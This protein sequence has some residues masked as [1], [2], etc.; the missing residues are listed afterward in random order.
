MLAAVLFVDP[1]GQVSRRFRRTT[2]YLDTP[3]CLRALGHE[4]EEAREAAWSFLHLARSQGATLACFQHSVREMRGIIQGAKSA[5]GRTVGAETAIRGVARHFRSTGATVSD[6]DLALA[7]LDKDLE[8]DR[9]QVVSSPEHTS[10]LGLDEAALEDLLQSEIGYRDEATRLADLNSLTAIHRLRGGQS[11]AHLETCRAVLVTSNWSLT[12]AS[13]RFFNSG[14]HEWPLVMMDSS[15]ATLLWVKAP[16]AQPDLPK[17]QI[18]ADCYAAMSPSQSMWTKF[19]GETRR[20][21]ERG[22]IDADS[23][24]LLRYS[25][26]AERALMDLTFGDQRRVN[27][28]VVRGALERARQAAADPAQRERDAARRIAQEASSAADEARFESERHLAEQQALQTRVEALEEQQRRRARQVVD[29]FSRRVRIVAGIA[30]G[31]GA[32]V[33]VASVLLGV[34]TFFP[35]L[36]RWIPHGLE[37]WLRVFAGVAIV[38]SGVTLWRG[39]SVTGWIEQRRDQAIEKRLQRENLIDP[40]RQ[41]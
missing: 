11:D 1:T 24:A 27:E 13:R 41:E 22:D 4:G 21:E 6:V 19:V 34:G 15:V 36:T 20:L 39:S 25:H 17:K 23:V 8:R 40:R 35:A 38:A 31:V 30:K 32:T 33:V 2:L 28:Q 12:R 9:I 5:L 10:A 7:S 3:I 26:E 16:M 29:S 14:R 37:L 18:I